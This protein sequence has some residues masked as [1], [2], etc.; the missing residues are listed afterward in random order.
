MVENNYLVRS[1]LLDPKQNVVGYK[2]AWQK[3]S[4]SSD[5]QLIELLNFVAPNIASAK[6][7]FLFLAANPAVF[8]AAA[9]QTL[10]PANTVLVLSRADLVD[11]ENLAR[12]SMLRSRGFKLALHD[13]DLAFLETDEVILPIITHLMLD[14]A[15]ANLAAINKLAKNR[16]IALTVVVD[17]LPSWQAFD[18][19]ALMGLSGF[20]KNLCTTPR[21][22]SS[23]QKLSWQAILLLQLMQLVQD[24]ADI[25]HL[26]KLLNQDASIAERLLGHLNSARFGLGGHIASVRQAV[27]MLG[28]KPLFR[29]LSL[30]LATTC[31]P[32]FCPA[33]LQT[34]IIRGRFIELLGQGVLPKSEADNLFIVGIFSLLDQLL[35]IPVDEIFSHVVLP[36]DVSKAL[37]SGDGVYGSYLALAVACEREDGG[38]DDVAAIAAAMGMDAV[39][40]NQAHM[41]AIVWAQNIKL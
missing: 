24:N 38:G 16:K 12:A 31:K 20:F 22:S 39:R 35:E 18:A 10:P 2:L 17:C 30:L 40:I 28:Y 27:T 34:A 36:E 37:R 7:G 9:L 11:E 33:M 5:G 3:N 41:A 23:N 26:E 29:W 15:D 32:G 4:P 1:P 14:A 13:A 19:R 21:P 25:Q 8:G 6:L